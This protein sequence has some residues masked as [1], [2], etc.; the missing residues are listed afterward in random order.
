MIDPQKAKGRHDIV[1]ACPFGAITW[2]AELDIP[3]HWTM[4][5]HLLD[6]GWK[7]SRAS[8]ACPT[9]ALVTQKVNQ[10]TYLTMKASADF[11]TDQTSPGTATHVFM[12]GHSKMG[13]VVLSGRV[14]GIRSGQ[15]Q[16]VQGAEVQLTDA[17]AD[18]VLF[19][20]KSDAF[21]IFKLE[22]GKP[23][24]DQINIV[25]RDEGFAPV[26]LVTTLDESKFLGE[27]SVN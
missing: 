5:A 21:G 20:T 17:T 12:R 24:G 23:S 22:N 9:G 16:C 10:S 26:S 4:D 13:K 7:E 2:N 18:R 27:I 14:V 25:I 8:Q 6:H 1:A 15:L 11:A 3:Q 19:S